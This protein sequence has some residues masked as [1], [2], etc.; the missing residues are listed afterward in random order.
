MELGLA[1]GDLKWLWRDSGLGKAILGL[2]MGEDRCERPG[3]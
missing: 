3:S 2:E 1:G